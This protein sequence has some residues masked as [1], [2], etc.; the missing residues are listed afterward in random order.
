MNILVTGSNGFIGAALCHALLNAGHQVRAFH[1]AS[2]NLQLLEGLFVEHAIG[3]LTQPETLQAAM[4][5][6]EV[7]FHTAAMMGRTNEPGQMYAVTVEGTRSVLEA[8]R[9]AGV[10]KFVH[11]SSV[12]ALGIPEPVPTRRIQPVVIDEKHTWNFT[13]THW[14]Y[15]YAKYLAELEV[16][17]AVARGMDAVI[18]NPTVVMGAGDIYRQSSALIVQAARQRFPAMLDGGIN[19]VHIDDVV[20]GHLAAMERGRTG[21]RYIL[22]GQNLTIPLFMQKMA[23]VAG[24]PAPTILLPSSLLRATAGLA[25]TLQNFIN[26]PI[27]PINLYVAGV[28]FF[29]SNRKAQ[30]ELGLPAPRPVEEAISDAYHWH[31]GTGAIKPPKMQ[32]D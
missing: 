1:R 23:I 21:E 31:V 12:A 30:I 13:P 19:I 22:G 4:Q 11:T 17:Q 32:S 2:S 7:V 14:P 9:Y 18:V 28:F 3:D 16:Q 6:I 8:A 10:R 20:A 27:N 15:G 29:Y 24:V 5:G 25:V 26:L